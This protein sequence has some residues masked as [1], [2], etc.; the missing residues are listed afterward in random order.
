MIEDVKYIDEKSPDAHHIESTAEHDEWS[1]IRED[2][3]I[4]EENERSMSVMTALKTYPAAVFWSFSISCC[5]SES[6]GSLW[7]SGV[8]HPPLLLWSFS[9][10]AADILCSHGGL[11]HCRSW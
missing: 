2:A 10:A 7:H 11:R 3:I 8:P 9:R 1:K 6:G 4:A 5:I